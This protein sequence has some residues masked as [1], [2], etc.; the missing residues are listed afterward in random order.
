MLP[1]E[2]DKVWSFLKEQPALSGFVLVGGSALALRI[3][4][5][6]SEDLDL[7][8]LEPQLPRLQIEALLRIASNVHLDFQ[9][10]DDESALDQFVQAGL[11]LHDYQ[12]NYVA[13]GTVKASFFVAD[14]AL[15]KVLAFIPE[16]KVRVATLA[17]LFKSNFR[18]CSSS[19]L[20]R[21]LTLA[22]CEIEAFCWKVL[23]P[24][25]SLRR[26]HL[27]FEIARQSQQLEI[28]VCGRREVKALVHHSAG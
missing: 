5:R 28:L 7:A 8:Y 22:L 9:R 15:I 20:A 11:D 27:G 25:A 4:H 21:C 3:N 23:H 6:R 17:E 24:P 16:S 18:K 19:A 2:T 13:N 14:N 10:N 26:E 1:L 12:Q